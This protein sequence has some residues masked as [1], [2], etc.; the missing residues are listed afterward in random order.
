[1]DTVI[2][3]DAGA[4][5]VNQD[6]CDG[7]GACIDNG[8]WAPGISC[9]DG[10]DCTNLEICDGAGVCVGTSDD[11]YCEAINPGDL[12]RPGCFA[13]AD[14]CG[15]PPAY[16]DLVCTS[17]VVLPGV[18]VCTVDL[19]GLEGQS[20]SGCLI[21]GSEVGLVTLDVADFSDALDACSLDGWAL[22][23]GV[24]CSS[25]VA[26]CMP[27]ATDQ[28]CCDD[29]SSI[30]TD[31]AGDKVLR[32]NRELNCSPT[33]LR[34]WRL[35]KTFDATGLEDL[36]VCF[37]FGE[38]GATS[39]E[40][41][42][43]YASDAVDDDQIFCRQ[44]EARLGEDYTLY[45]FCA[46]LPAWANN[47]PAVT[48][49]FIAHSRDDWD[50]LYLDDI[51]VRGWHQTCA[52]TYQDVFS[53]DFDACDLTD[54]NVNGAPTCPGDFSCD[55]TNNLWA[56]GSPDSWSI[57]RVIDISVLDGSVE[58][59]F[60]FGDDHADFGDSIHV[61][62]DPGT[63]WQTAWYQNGN[64]GQD[65]T[66]YQVCV[67]LSNI[68][69]TVNRNS[70]LGIRFT[71]TSNAWSD[72]IFLDNVLLRGAIYCDGSGAILLGAMSDETGGIYS[73]TATD[74]SGAR[75]DGDINCYWDLPPVPIEDWS[76][77]EYMP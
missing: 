25:D 70:A 59:C 38:S 55:G 43:V 62:F 51:V 71:L 64:M 49:T 14:G 48:L 39:N 63:G 26:N 61:E 58:L 45:P 40:A 36:E 42:L 13:S 56:E 76:H 73:F 32:S 10:Y 7:S 9:D 22:E 12:C 19:D 29:F 5:C 69:P 68:D 24:N 21:C 15:T 72:E 23:S 46:S 60:E 17:P 53:D 52:P 33:D 1:A 67:N 37:D 11:S 65:N 47:N 31:L 27:D 77:V 75:L 44:G 2:C 34:Q 50:S 41:L 20:S 18:S 8:Y 4:D 54:W 66:C 35:Y 28:S 6:L 74:L 16:L 30:C 3:G 57:D